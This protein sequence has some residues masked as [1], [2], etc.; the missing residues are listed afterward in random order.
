MLLRKK[1][2]AAVIILSLAG[3][4][5]ITFIL[6]SQYTVPI[7]MYHHI[8]QSGADDRLSVSADNFKKQME[9]L[10][11]RKYKVVSLEELIKHLKSQ[12]PLPHNLVAIT[13]D[14]GYEDSYLNAFPALKSNN[15][16]A[17]I[18]L[19]TNYIGQEG[20]LIWKEIQEMAANRID[21]GAHTK[22]HAWLASLEDIQLLRDQIL[23]SKTILEAKLNRPVNFFCYP[24]GGISDLAKQVVV[25]SGY[26]GACATHPGDKYAKYDIYALRRIKISN[27]DNLFGFWIKASGYYTLF[28]NK[29]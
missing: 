14:D 26:H 6:P 25:E 12:K 17:E 27:S 19:I 4:G 18:F 5:F 1:L 9:F 10:S 8:Q 23:G 13:I 28:K 24:G 29:K 11:K 22:T 3:A 7:L 21:F 20:Y 16:P 2:L 15:L